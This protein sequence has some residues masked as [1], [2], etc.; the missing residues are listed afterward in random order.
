MNGAALRHAR[1]EGVRCN[2]V[3]MQSGYAGMLAVNLQTGVMTLLGDQQVRLLS[4]GSMVSHVSGA[5][6]DSMLMDYTM[7]DDGPVMLLRGTAFD[8]TFNVAY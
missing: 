1:V 6:S 4:E 7:L 2:T 3:L 8:Q 5:A